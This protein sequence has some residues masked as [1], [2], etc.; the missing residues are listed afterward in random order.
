LKLQAD[1][2]IELKERRDG[3]LGKKADVSEVQDA[4]RQV[5]HRISQME[6]VQTQLDEKASKA[7]LTYHLQKKVSIDEIANYFA[8]ANN[9]QKANDICVAPT[10]PP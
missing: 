6:N 2:I 9:I 3:E 10:P 4:L 1:Q 5:F 8:L 7:E